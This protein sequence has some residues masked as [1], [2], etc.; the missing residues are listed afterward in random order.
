MA[1]QIARRRR[2]T[3][4]V[5]G[6]FALAV[7][8]VLAQA[9]AAAA[10][11][12]ITVSPSSAAPGTSVTVSGN[13]PVSGTASCAAGDP[14]QLTSSDG[15]FPP[16]GFGPQA[17]RDASGNFSVQYT[18]PA[19]TPAGSYSIGLRCG[20]GNVGITASLTVT[21]NGLPATGSG[22]TG[23]LV[24]TGLTLILVGLVLAR[25]GNKRMDPTPSRA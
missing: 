21:S 16:D 12:S 15:L 1:V 10:A 14:A 20:G 25:R 7:L 9:S 3:S 8:A 2:T 23:Q 5:V 18:I 6:A 19:S 4:R 17:Q 22:L 13:I 24:V 11:A